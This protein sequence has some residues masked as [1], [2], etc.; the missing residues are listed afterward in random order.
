M[1]ANFCSLTFGPG[2]GGG[3][4]ACATLACSASLA[5]M[6][7][8]AGDDS[9]TS[10]RFSRQW[11]RDLCRRLHSRMGWQH[12]STGGTHYPLFAWRI[13]LEAGDPRADKARTHGPCAYP[14]QF[15]GSSRYPTPGVSVQ[16]THHAANGDL[17]FRIYKGE[18]MATSIVLSEISSRREISAADAVSAVRFFPAFCV[19][20]RRS[21]GR[22]PTSAMRCRRPAALHQR[23]NTRI[24]KKSV[25]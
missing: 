15:A 10:K 23:R 13:V 1:Q 5:A 25:S 11:S 18:I 4:P 9:P 20:L 17:R 22:T 2:R 6:T 14:V 19:V 8:S 21:A 3:S 24:S 16:D 7:W 12:F